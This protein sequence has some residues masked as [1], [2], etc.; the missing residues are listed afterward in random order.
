M[1]DLLCGEI[2]HTVIRK[3]WIKCWNITKGIFWQANL[4]SGDFSLMSLVFQIFLST[5]RI[6]FTLVFV[7]VRILFVQVSGLQKA[8]CSRRT[9]VRTVA[10]LFAARKIY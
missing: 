1:K 3:L 9:A 10:L 5:I 7:D 8:Q 2:A 4:C 6:Q